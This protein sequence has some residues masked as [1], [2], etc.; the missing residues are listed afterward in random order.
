MKYTNHFA[1]LITMTMILLNILNYASAK[2]TLGTH[3]FHNINEQINGIVW[4]TLFDDQ[5]WTYTLETTLDKGDNK[6][7]Q[8]IQKFNPE[9]SLE[10]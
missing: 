3:K 8:R 1:A 5:S 10:A 4:H 9:L 2:D 6:K 7:Q